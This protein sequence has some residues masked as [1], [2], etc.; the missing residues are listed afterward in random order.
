MSNNEKICIFNKNHL[1]G[2]K[3]LENHYLRSHGKEYAKIMKN[4][5][6]CRDR[7][8]KLFLNQEEMDKHVNKCNKCKY[9]FG[10]QKRQENNKNPEN[11]ENSE[12]EITESDN[13][14]SNNILN[15]ISVAGMKI[16]KDKLPKDKNKITF[17]IFDFDKYKNHEDKLTSIDLELINSLIEEE[18]NLF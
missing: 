4:G 8:F 14:E 13:E 15:D 11:S 10:R 3:S 7:K 17:P 16:I 5:W 6:F 9:I 1:L 12:S 2:K 18:K